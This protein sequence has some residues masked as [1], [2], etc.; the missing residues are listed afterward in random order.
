MPGT[1][2]GGDSILYRVYIIGGLVACIAI[3]VSVSL[4]FPGADETLWMPLIFGPTTLWF[5]GILAY[6]WVQLLFLGYAD[7]KRLREEAGEDEP[8]IKA[9][10]SWRQ[11]PGVPCWNGSAGHPCSPFT[12]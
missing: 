8:E 4:L 5:L 11:P 12:A 9:L 7:P 3:A 6:W 1:G 2:A 10:R